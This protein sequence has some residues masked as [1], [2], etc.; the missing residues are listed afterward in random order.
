MLAH[1]IVT[2]RPYAFLDDEE[3]QNRRTN[4]VQLRRG[5]NVDL[6]SIGALDPDA[7]E[8]VHAEIA[9]TPSTPDDLHD[10][11]SSLVVVLGPGRLAAA[12]GG[13]ALTGAG[14][15]PSDPDGDELWCT[16]ECAGEAGLAFDGDDGA[17]VR[18]PCAV[19]SS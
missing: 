7:I 8:Q 4:A 13:A 1:E 15:G 17:V 10:L 14:P 11:L 16:T 6:T 5:L 19:I 12:V 2:A 18:M 3:F 9:P